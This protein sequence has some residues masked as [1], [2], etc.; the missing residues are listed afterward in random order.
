VDVTNPPDDG[1]HYAADWAAQA[2]L[3]HE[4]V[5]HPC[6]VVLIARSGATVE[7]GWTPDEEVL[8]RVLH[9]RVR[10]P[11]SSDDALEVAGEITKQRVPL[12]GPAQVRIRF[13]GPPLEPERLLELLL[14]LRSV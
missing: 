12:R 10:E 6:R 2:R 8:E 11:A 1:T 3:D 13:V 5:W 4:S 14:Q 7:L 9:L